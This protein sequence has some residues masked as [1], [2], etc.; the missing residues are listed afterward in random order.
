MNS[1]TNLLI[2]LLLLL[3][4]VIQCIFGNFPFAFLAFPLDALIALLWTVGMS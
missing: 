3:S 2:I 1:K 4:V